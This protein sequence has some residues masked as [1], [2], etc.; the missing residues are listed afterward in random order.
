MSDEYAEYVGRTVVME[1]ILCVIKKHVKCRDKQ[2]FALE[3]QEKLP[4]SGS[5]CPSCVQRHVELPPY[6]GIYEMVDNV[7]RA[8]ERQKATEKRSKTPLGFEHEVC[9]TENR[10]PLSLPVT[11]PNKGIEGDS[12]SCYMDATIFCMFPYTDVFDRL[13][14]MQVDDNLSAIRYYTFGLKQLDDEQEKELASKG[15]SSM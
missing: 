10:P 4:R 3:T 2:Y 1:G 11:G 7:L 14:Y 6:R 9:V 12:N 5:F 15:Q 13:L 8:I